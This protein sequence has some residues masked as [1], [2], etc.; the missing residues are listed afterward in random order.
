MNPATELAL[1]TQCRRL[2][3]RGMEVMARIGAHDFERQGPQRVSIDVDVYVALAASTPQ[4][5]KLEEVLDYDFIRR[6]V[7]ERIGHG[8][9][10]L[11]ETLCDDLLA[12]MLAFPQVRAARVRTAKPDVYPA[13]AAVGCERFAIKEST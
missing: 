8:H 11:Q 7:F 2:F 13:C 12:C 6:S 3:V 5:D 4:R 9:I 1:L 10:E